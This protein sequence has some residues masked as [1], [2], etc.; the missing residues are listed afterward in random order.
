MENTNMPARRDFLKAS[1]AF[2]I[3]SLSFLGLVEAGC[4][5]SC[6]GL[7]DSGS[8]PAD[9]DGNDRGNRYSN[10]DGDG[11]TNGCAQPH[12]SGCLHK[13]GGFCGGCDCPG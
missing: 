7:C 1:S 9:P 3:T 11:N 2:V 6:A 8:K 13:P 12:R 10:G 4:T 5:N